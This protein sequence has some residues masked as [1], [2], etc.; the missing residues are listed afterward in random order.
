MSLV[1]VYQSG[2]SA[3][4]VLVREWHVGTKYEHNEHTIDHVT[5]VQADGHELEWVLR[6]FNNIPTIRARRVMRWHGDI[7]KFI[8]GQLPAT[9]LQV[10]STLNFKL[11]D[12]LESHGAQM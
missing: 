2:A 12:N 8:A 9:P 6:E 10:E 5:E 3:A 4:S 11:V 1:V 7:A